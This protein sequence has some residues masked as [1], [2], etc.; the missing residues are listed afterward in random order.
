MSVANFISFVVVGM[1][2]FF[3]GVWSMRVKKDG[4]IKINTTDP[5]KDVY[6]IVLDIPLED[7]PKRSILHLDVEVS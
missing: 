3:V 2:C 7:I 4:T 1:V 6:S 5:D